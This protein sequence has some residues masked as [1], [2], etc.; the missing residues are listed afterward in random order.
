MENQWKPKEN[1]LFQW[2]ANENLRNLGNDFQNQG[3]LVWRAI[4]Q[5]LNGI[6]KGFLS[7]ST[8][9]GLERILVEFRSKSMEIGMESF[10]LTSQWNPWGIPSHYNEHWPGENP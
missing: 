5:F 7:K 6:L 2:K 10:W 8:E 4:G 1:K 3:K 9:I